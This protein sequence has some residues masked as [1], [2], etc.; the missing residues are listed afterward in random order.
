MGEYGVGFRQVRFEVI[1]DYMSRRAL[2]QWS[3]TI[4]QFRREV[5]VG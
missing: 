3:P 1:A 2:K 5:C 4:L